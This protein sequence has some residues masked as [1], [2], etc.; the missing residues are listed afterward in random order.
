MKKMLTGTKC[1]KGKK[2]TGNNVEWKK[3]PPGQNVE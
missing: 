3:Y 1:Q 2:L